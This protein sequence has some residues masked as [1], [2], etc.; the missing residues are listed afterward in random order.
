MRLETAREMTYRVKAEIWKQSWTQLSS[1]GMLLPSQQGASR[2]NLSPPVLNSTLLYG[3]N[4]TSN[5][6][7]GQEMQG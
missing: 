5:L 1:Q 7:A 4:A 2:V 6:S 3:D